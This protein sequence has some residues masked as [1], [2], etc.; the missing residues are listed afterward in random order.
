MCALV[1]FG[2]GVAGIS[3]KIGG[4]V[5]ARN[6]SGAYAR[7]WVSPI[8]P[9]TTKQQAERS[10][11]A[12]LVSTW[13]GL[14]A[15]NQTAWTDMAPQ[16]PYQNR[17]GEQSEYSGQQ[18]YMHLNRNLQVV[19]IAL[20]VTPRVPGVFSSATVSTLE[21]ELTANVLTTAEIV[22][23]AAGL[24][25]E[26]VIVEITSSVSGG[27]TKP[28][29]GLFRQV[30]INGDA[31][32]GPTFDFVSEYIALYGNPLVGDKIFARAWMINED[33]GQRMLLGQ[34]EFLVTT[35]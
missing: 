25:T 2:G 35:V 28:A 12:S 15:A 8:N 7:N 3:G 5:F 17:L 14:T 29:K 31:S 34:A 6:K 10:T 21:M 20:L 22:L 4:T 30:L 9:N 26:S 23:T 33:T 11:F 27:I 18:L 24:S 13:K 32:T 1:K 16:Y 19:N